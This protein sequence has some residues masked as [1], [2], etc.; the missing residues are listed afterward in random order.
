MLSVFAIFMAGF[1]LVTSPIWITLFFFNLPWIIGLYYALFYTTWFNP[2]I[3]MFWKMSFGMM[4]KMYQGK[5]MAQINLGYA[6]L[7]KKDGI[8]LEGHHRTAFDKYRLQL[9]HHCV[10]DNGEL[11]NMNNKTLLETGCGRGGG[12]NYI[13]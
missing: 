5:E 6:D 11:Q 4:T 7:S 10:I 8:F 2:A 3:K 12:L 9:Y 1:L 13:V